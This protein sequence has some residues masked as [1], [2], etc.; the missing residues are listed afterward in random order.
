MAQKQYTSVAEQIAETAESPEFAKQVQR[1]IARRQIID[2]LM[3]L[4]ALRG[5]SQSDVA[6][7][8]VCS[9]SRI[10]KLENGRDDD[11]RLGD[12]DQYVSAL[13][14]DIR[15]VLTRRRRSDF[16]EVKYHAFSIKRILDKIARLSKGDASMS[17]G[18]AKIMAETF[19]N[20]TSFIGGSLEQ[21]VLPKSRESQIKMEIMDED[22]ELPTA[23]DDCLDEHCAAAL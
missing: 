22:A 2:H 23:P 4:R 20:M 11:L 13:G 16:D 3:A 8:L 9:Q 10:S 6:K 1:Q 17:A 18:A 7:K 21:L 14:M 15:I 5:L 12:L 19:Y